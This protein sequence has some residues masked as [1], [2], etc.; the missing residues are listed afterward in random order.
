VEPVIEQLRASQGSVSHAASKLGVS[1]QHLHK[2]ISK[3]PTVAEALADVRE[4]TIDRLDIM[5]LDRARTSDRVLIF[6][7]ETL[8]KHRGYV[9]RQEHSGPD[10]GP[11]EH[12]DMSRVSET[13][14]S[15]IARIA[16]RLEAAA[17]SS[18]NSPDEP[19]TDSS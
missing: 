2:F 6:L 18:G 11:I 19:G 9:R 10:G 14:E 4:T 7:L 5:A 8:G 1:R 3:H 13:L 17:A 16:A 15:R 12:K